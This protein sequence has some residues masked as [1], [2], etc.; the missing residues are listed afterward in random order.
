[1]NTK[2]KIFQYIREHRT[3]TGKE[4][5]EYFDISRQALNKHIKRLIQS[6]RIIKKGVT[7]GVTYHIS[8]KSDH[9]QQLQK[10]EREYF[11]SGLQEDI[12]FNEISLLLNL[13]RKLKKNVLDIVEYG[14]TE[15]LNNSIEHSHSKICRVNVV[16]DN[17]NLNF[18]IRDYGIGVFYLS[19]IH[20]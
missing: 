16:L 12:V 6:G 20:I 15:M 11:L 7:K 8:Q 19:L 2:E 14:F 4:L 5:C 17:Y 18:S 3:A 9:K 1:M 10:I 13:K